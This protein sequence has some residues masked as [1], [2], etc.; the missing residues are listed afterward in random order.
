MHTTISTALVAATL[1]VNIA[2]AYTQTLG[3]SAL[4]NAL[5][6]TDGAEIDALYAPR[7]PMVRMWNWGGALNGVNADL[8]MN[9]WHVDYPFSG[10]AV[11][12]TMPQRSIR[13]IL[14]GA[15]LVMA[16]SWQIP[17]ARYQNT[18]GG[19]SQFPWFTD[20]YNDDVNAVPPRRALVFDLGHGNGPS[21]IEAQGMRFHPELS[22]DTAILTPRPGDRQRAVWGFRQL[23]KQASPAGRRY[24]ISRGRSKSFVSGP[25]T[26]SSSRR[27][28]SMVI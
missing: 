2:T 1:L 17:A 28:R 19:A 25:K 18:T 10:H 13:R 3:P 22:V 26:D 7:P 21:L 4:R 12:D 24:L 23:Q 11:T 27:G 8:R 14:P 9:G 15:R 6:A 20:A 5:N 16:P